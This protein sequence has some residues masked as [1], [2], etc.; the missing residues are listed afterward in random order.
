M[1]E[2]SI[3]DLGE[4]R[5]GNREV[6]NMVVNFDLQYFF[7]AKIIN[8]KDIKIT[9]MVH[10]RMDAMKNIIIFFLSCSYSNKFI[11]DLKFVEALPLF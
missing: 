2:G 8:C 6:G 4:W 3:K 10:Q 1:I 5:I 9:N 7:N 11:K